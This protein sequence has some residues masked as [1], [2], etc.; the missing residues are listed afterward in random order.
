M[1]SQSV[2]ALLL[3]STAECWLPA[4]RRRNCW[5]PAPRRRKCWQP[6]S[7][8]GSSVATACGAT[9]RDVGAAAVGAALAP[10]VARAA[11]A[12]TKVLLAG[13]RLGLELEDAGGRVRV[14]RV[15]EGTEAYD[16]G[17]T[18]LAYVVAINGRPVPAGATAADVGKA[19]RSAPRPV[20]LALDIDSAYAGLDR[21]SAPVCKSNLQP[22]F[23]VRVFECFDTSTSSVLR[24]L[25]ES[26]RFVQKSAESTSI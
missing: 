23:N 10:A 2:A 25:A 24:E 11:P 12:T 3:L 9:R 16:K 18:P 7:R 1:R 17:V 19:L 13:E 4:P 21:A 14:R 6:A 22:D 26:N 8:C 20:E 15:R 5:Q